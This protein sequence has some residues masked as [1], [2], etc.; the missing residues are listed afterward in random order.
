[1]DLYFDDIRQSKEYTLKNLSDAFIGEANFIRRIEQKLQIVQDAFDNTWHMDEVLLKK[2]F[3]NFVNRYKSDFD[4]IN[5]ADV[6]KYHHLRIFIS[7]NYGDMFSKEKTLA[8]VYLV[9]F[10]VSLQ[11]FFPSYFSKYTLPYII[12]DQYVIYITFDEEEVSDV[13]TITSDNMYDIT[14]PLILEQVPLKGKIF[15][16]ISSKNAL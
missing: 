12:D 14:A 5:F 13:Q 15:T 1:M 8:H 2:Q 11:P 16:K 7:N 4:V 10:H 6:D 3:Y 9:Y